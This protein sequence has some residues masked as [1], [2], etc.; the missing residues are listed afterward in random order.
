MNPYRSLSPSI[1]IWNREYAFTIYR[2]SRVTKYI[3]SENLTIYVSARDPSSVF[4]LLKKYTCAFHTYEKISSSGDFFCLVDPTGVSPSKNPMPSH[5]VFLGTEFATSATT[6]VDRESVRVLTQAIQMD[7]C[8]T[9]IS[10]SP[11]ISSSLDSG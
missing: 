4:F 5:G 7:L 10:P 8:P 2:V 9:G 6:L 11:L 1:F 3:V